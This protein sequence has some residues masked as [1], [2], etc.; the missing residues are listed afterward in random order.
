[1]KDA[2]TQIGSRDI[3][4]FENLRDEVLASVYTGDWQH[5]ASVC[6]EAL[7]RAQSRDFLSENALKCLY[8][9]DTVKDKFHDEILQNASNRFLRAEK[10]LAQFLKTTAQLQIKS[11]GYVSFDGWKE[12]TGLDLNRL[13][14]LFRT[15]LA[16]Q[17]TAG[18]SNFCRRCNEWALPGPRRHFS[19]DAAVKLVD[20]LAGENNLRF[21][22][23][24]ASDP[25]DWQQGEKDLRHLMDA[26]SRRGNTPVY[27]LLTKVPR[28]KE[29]VFQEL[30]QRGAD[31]SASITERNRK[32]IEA[33]EKK[34]G[35]FVNKQHDTDDLL[36]PARLDEDFCS[37]KPSVSDSYG[38]E[39]TPDGAFITIPTF[40]SALNPTGQ[41]RIPVTDE[42]R[43]FLRKREGRK[44]L[45]VDYFNP[46]DIIDTQGG[47]TTLGFL[48]DA[49]IENIL[50]DDGSEELTPPGMTSLR[51][52]FDTFETA[53][54]ERRKKVLPSVIRRLEK[55][56]SGDTLLKKARAYRRFTE[57]RF[58]E[59]CRTA[60][61]S[62]FLD[63][64]RDYLKRHKA[65]KDIITYLRRPDIRHL[66]E[67][68]QISKPGNRITD[69]LTSRRQETFDVF[70]LLLFELLDNPDSR[71]ITT[72]IRA[73]PSRYDTF[74]E[75]FILV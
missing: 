36:I 50:L 7:N 39:I 59:D 47:K 18:C 11:P 2:E 60:A 54:V 13:S 14:L 21:T 70:S 49:Q 38:T 41:K 1:M 68:Y 72:F 75:R 52:Y 29:A 46:L 57:E 10:D 74:S 56:Y 67:K 63:A 33:I 34:T 9:I 42:T 73:N 26:V 58:V 31:I 62:F 40:T 6:F 3:R 5:M 22:L 4:I 23:Y 66:R 25:L 64:V 17:L 20:S 55:K 51:E 37:V 45:S 44:G 43:F 28:G 19:Y 15:T 35:I 30:L 24:G 32:R 48:L 12:R 27:G 65:R 8:Q 69:L 16:L 53:A 71:D 61:V